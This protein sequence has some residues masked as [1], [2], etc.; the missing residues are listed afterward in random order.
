MGSGLYISPYN[1]ESNAKENGNETEALGPFKGVYR[2]STPNP[3]CMGLGLGLPH[4]FCMDLPSITIIVISGI[5][6]YTYICT[7]ICIYIY[8]FGVVLYTAL[9]LLLVVI[10]LYRPLYYPF[11]VPP[12]F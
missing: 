6:V 10:L 5:Y 7:Y 2:D 4:P 8:I 1:G 9:L 12:S 11:E 3:R